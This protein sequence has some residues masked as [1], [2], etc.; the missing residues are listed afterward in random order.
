MGLAGLIFYVAG[1]HRETLS[2]EYFSPHS[3]DGKQFDLQRI[4]GL[5]YVVFPVLH[6]SQEIRPLRGCSRLCNLDTLRKSARQ[7]EHSAAQQV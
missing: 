4:H 7:E 1:S 2:A 5:A 6:D 3:L